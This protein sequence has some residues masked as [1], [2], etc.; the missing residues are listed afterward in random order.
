MRIIIAPDSFKR[1]LSAEAVAENIVIGLTEVFPR[2]KMV[3]MP[4]ADGGEGTL[5]VIT[6]NAQNQIVSMEAT[7]PIGRKMTTEFGI[8]ADGT[9]VIETAKIIGLPLLDAHEKNPLITSSY[10]VG[11]LIINAL[12][13]GC[14]KFIIGLG[15]SATNDAGLGMMQALGAKFLDKNGKLLQNGGAELQKLYQIDLSGLDLRLKD[16]SFRVACDVSNPLLGKNGAT[17]TYAQQKGATQAQIEILEN[18]LQKFYQVVLN[19]FDKAISDVEGAGAAG[20]LGAGFYAFLNTELCNGFQL[21]S[22]LIEVEKYLPNT[23]FVITGEGRIDAQTPFGKLPFGMARLAKKHGIPCIG[24]AGMVENKTET[25]HQAGMT[26][27]FS[28]TDRPLSSED[29][30]KN[31]PILIQKTAAQIGRLIRAFRLA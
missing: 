29:S 18:A 4:Q 7:D 11:E 28:I 5:S 14:R 25:L 31:A 23:D 2:A 8:L 9:A 1:C 17:R 22:E 26:A 30:V 12:A 15:G 27:I 3:V 24:I 21:I 6:K 10:G 19:Q 13:H 16:A 20:G